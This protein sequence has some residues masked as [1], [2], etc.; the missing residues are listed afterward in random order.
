M[1]LKIAV[2][3][4]I[5][6]S[7]SV[8]MHIPSTHANE[9]GQRRILY[10]STGCEHCKN[11]LNELDKYDIQEKL[12]IEYR[13]SSLF[14]IEYRSDFTDCFPDSQ[15][16][17]V[18]FMVYEGRCMTGEKEIKDFLLT[19]AGVDTSHDGDGNT[20]EARTA[21][22][23]ASAKDNTDHGTILDTSNDSISKN[24]NRNSH[25]SFLQ[26]FG[27]FSGVAFF[28]LIGYIFVFRFR[29]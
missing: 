11:L 6:L 13:E 8:F 3:I 7:L 15:M 5:L 1:N 4:A 29:L 27:I 16:R 17:T 21:D 28:G 12:D 2:S 18:P 26:T 23:E 14:P 22:Q 10:H 20:D 19:R 9:D 25:L 24:D